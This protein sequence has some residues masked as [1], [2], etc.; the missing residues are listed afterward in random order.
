VAE[1]LLR[2]KEKN[3]KEAGKCPPGLFKNVSFLNYNLGTQKCIT[4]VKVFYI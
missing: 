2:E 4:I 3:S 1:S